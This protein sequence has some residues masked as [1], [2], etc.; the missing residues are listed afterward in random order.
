MTSRK[1]PGVAFW[2]TVVVVAALI[3]Y[4]LSFGPACWIAS[5]EYAAQDLTLTIYQ[6]LVLMWLNSPDVLRHAIDWY[7][8]VGAD[9]EVVPSNAGHLDLYFLPLPAKI[10]R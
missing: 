8:N 7:A 2:A 1:K 3:L 10:P 9:G 4:P 5:R 6:P